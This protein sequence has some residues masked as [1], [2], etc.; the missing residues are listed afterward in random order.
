MEKGLNIASKILITLVTLL[1]TAFFTV[2]FVIFFKSG[3][4]PYERILIL[5]STFI[6]ILFNIANITK[7]IKNEDKK[8]KIVLIILSIIN[9]I[10]SGISI[11]YYFN[12]PEKYITKVNTGTLI[13]IIDYLFACIYIVTEKTIVKLKENEND[14]YLKAINPSD[15]ISIILMVLFLFLTIATKPK[16]YQL[17]LAMTFILFISYTIILKNWDITDKCLSNVLVVISTIIYFVSGICFKRYFDTIEKYTLS[18]FC[19]AMAVIFM[20]MANCLVL[21]KKESLTKKIITTVLL[22]SGIVLFAVILKDKA[23][24]LEHMKKINIYRIISVFL[25]YIY[26]IKNQTGYILQKDGIAI[27][28]STMSLILGIVFMVLT[29]NKSNELYYIF[30]RQLEVY[31]AI[32]LVVLLIGIAYQMILSRKEKRTNQN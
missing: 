18:T 27:V 25:I 17:N 6:L 15:Y 10:I 24:R 13:F 1:T 30:F 14:N 31:S 21:D 4:Y 32:A 16:S 5:I 8:A 11:Y 19:N 26:V 3:S 7:Q 20:I 12:T 2:Y 22:I 9:I 28:I 29:I 23:V